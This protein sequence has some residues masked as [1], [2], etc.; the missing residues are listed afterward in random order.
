MKRLIG[1]LSIMACQ[2]ILGIEDRALDPITD[3]CELPSGG[4]AAVRFA[5][6]S[7]NGVAVDLCLSPSSRGI[8]RG[9]GRGCPSGLGYAQVSR[10]FDV[11]SGNYDLKVIKYGDRCD[12][13]AL[14]ELRGQ[15]IAP[16]R[17]TTLA[18]VGGNQLKPFVADA[19]LTTGKTLVR[20]INAVPDGPALDLG[21]A[22]D[23]RPPAKLLQR[24]FA[25]P[26]RYGEST[27]G[28][29]GVTFPA[30]PDGY[31]TV[32]SAST[33]VGAAPAGTDRATI[34]TGVEG[35]DSVRTLYAIGDAAQPLLPLR[36]LLCDDLAREPSCTLTAL[37]TLSVDVVSAG[38]FGGVAKAEAERRLP[39][40]QKIAQRDADFVCVTQIGRRADKS[41]LIALAKPRFPY[42]VNVDTN[43]DTK[44]TAPE[45]QK[46]P[47]IVPSCGG[48]GDPTRTK[49]LLDCLSTKCTTTGN[50]EGRLKSSGVWTK[51]NADCLS[52]SCVA[53]FISLLDGATEEQRVAHARCYNC[54]IAT[55]LSDKTMAEVRGTCTTD[56]R[57]AYS[58]D[59]ETPSLLLSRFALREQASFI[60]PATTYRRAVHFARAE[61]E[62]GK[63]VDVYCGHINANFGEVVPYGGRFSSKT[64]SAAWLEERALEVK[65]L[66][67]F[68]NAKSGPGRHV[69]L[70]G[71]WDSSN[72]IRDSMGNVVIKSRDPD[73]VDALDAV[74]MRAIPP[75]HVP[76]CTMCPDNR[77]GN[78]VLELLP[79][80]VYTRSFPDAAATEMSTF[81]K[82]A[83]VPMPGGDLAPLSGV[84]GLNVRVKR[85]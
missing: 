72:E 80:R 55:F 52:E 14:A 74:F 57:D 42:V 38:L 33:N 29:Q 21:L 70:A 40:L 49:A 82:E 61:I 25:S 62:P 20:L 48:A 43:V 24:L 12:A 50:D 51:P 39:I 10:L 18:H 1:L 13:P 60:L 69:I 65:R 8:L 68:V 58:F 37:S 7:P 47:R 67:E 36:G 54:A 77:V 71:E 23:N 16:G 41:E 53:E 6:L 73:V 17:T 85:P 56:I 81:F 3:G 45:D 66:I 9:G 63:E 30:T 34:A 27:A 22:G 15:A 32:P 46:P 5:N 28:I 2:P 84:Y 83:I 59:G 64:G 78:A 35:F 76:E 75:G 79:T 31:S 44:P 26:V 11:R 4:D 19:K